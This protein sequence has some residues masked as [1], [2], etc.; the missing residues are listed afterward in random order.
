MDFKPEYKHG[1]LDIEMTESLRLLGLHLRS[2]LKWIDNTAAMTKKGYARLW[3]IKRLKTL[4][5][6]QEDLKDVYEKQVRSVLEFGAPVWNS[7]ISKQEVQDIERIQKSFL[8]IVLGLEY[9]EYSTALKKLEMETLESRRHKLCVKFA[10]KAAK[11]PKHSKWFKLDSDPATSAR[12][13]LPEARLKRFKTSP[14]PY[15]TDLLNSI[16]SQE[17]ET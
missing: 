15:L 6:S 7:N 3:I 16:P 12:Y 8:R 4:G 10:F 5:A 13:C 2:D 17:W 11:D 14:I 9:S 1:E